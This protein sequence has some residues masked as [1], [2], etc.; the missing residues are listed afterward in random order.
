M[1]ATPVWFGP[2]ARP[3][4]GWFHA[5]PMQRARGG[6]V[7]CPPF[8][9]EHLQAHYTL[10]LLAEAL[11][12]RGLAVLRLDYDGMGDSAGDGRDPARVASWLAS[13]RRGIDLLATA[14]IR[15]ISLVG[16]RIGATLAAH[17]AA[18]RGAVH[19]LVLWDPCVSGRGYLREQ[20]AVTSLA[21]RGAPRWK[22]GSVDTPGLLFTPEA[23][24]EMRGL[25]VSRVPGPVAERVL[26]LTRD[27]R[28][29]SEEAMAR[30]GA[31]GAEHRAAAGQADL[32]DVEMP[33][34]QLPYALISDVAD[35]LGEGA[36]R[37]P[38]PVRAPPPAGPAVVGHTPEGWPVVER[39]V[40][41]A[42]AG[43]FGMVTEVPGRVRPGP[44][45]VFISVA[46]GHHVGPNRMWVELARRW[47]A[48]GMRSIRFDLSGVG[49]SPVRW[50][51]QEHFVA[52]SP[53]AFADVADV[54]RAVSP[55]NPRDVVLVGHC[56]SAYQA[57][58]SALEL[59]VAGVVALN[60]VLTFVPPELERHQPLDGR[61]RV[62]LPRTPF[63]ESFHGT[64]RLS[65]VRE[66][67]PSL[68]WWI[69]LWS[70]PR[71]RPGSWLR[72]ILAA[73]TDVLVVN[74]ERENRP[75][76]LGMTRP[77]RARLERTGRLRIE[78]QPRLEHGL[79]LAEQRAMVADLVTRH[80]VGRSRP[81]QA[82]PGDGARAGLEQA[83]TATTLADDP[84]P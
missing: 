12:S 19:Q 68:G 24:G 42:P 56:A 36:A 27:G 18:D 31:A 7:I 72:T 57:F 23:A 47:A 71:R 4:F 16:M 81:P 8:I 77:L 13:V 59:G 39:P 45:G 2:A 64:G 11:E 33:W 5:P 29:R 30:L 15:D 6:V 40:F 75:F 46:N 26:V 76:R 43:L 63:V 79:L 53:E 52:R 84:V 34:L 50:A 22:D 58:E 37:E 1:T 49:D 66:H 67:L 48:T 9:R 14:G 69:R 41:V 65:R 61:R 35:W 17:A 44:A 20:G 80:V 28:E 38:T 55:A 10:R 83:L 32:M 3:L 70:H 25:D 54:A 21:L 51:G 60:P 73:G 82:H 62:A 78:Y 74:G